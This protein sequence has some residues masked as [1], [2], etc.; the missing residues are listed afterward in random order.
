MKLLLAIIHSAEWM[1]DDS[2]GKGIRG[3]SYD[4]IKV[5]TLFSWRF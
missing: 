5:I 3:S 4:L 2:F 1:A